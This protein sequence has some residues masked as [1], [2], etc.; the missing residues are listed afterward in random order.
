M[1]KHVSK[2]LALGAAPTKKSKGRCGRSFRQDNR[3]SERAV[4]AS[5]CTKASGEHV[6]D[7]DRRQAQDTRLRP[8]DNL[9]PCKSTSAQTCEQ[10]TSV[11]EENDFV[12]IESVNEQ[13]S[14]NTDQSATNEDGFAL[15]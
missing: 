3:T 4:N 9:T 13:K 2:S 11:Q 7:E 15:V 6:S 10:Q 1:K 5:P 12:D 14:P 8:E